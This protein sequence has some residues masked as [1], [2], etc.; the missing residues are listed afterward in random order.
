MGRFH[1]DWETWAQ[2]QLIDELVLV[3]GD[4][5]RF[6]AD[7]WL[8]HSADQFAGARENGLRV[9]LWAATE[10]R[11]DE[12]PTGIAAP[13]PLYIER[14]R[15]LFIGVMENALRACYDQDADGVFMHEA[16]HA[17]KYDYFDVLQRV[18]GAV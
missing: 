4:H 16:W 12:L 6:G 14:N 7:D 17:E 5:R 18:F 13:L 10:H 8:E 15:G 1:L 9:Y 2:Q 3:A 11:I